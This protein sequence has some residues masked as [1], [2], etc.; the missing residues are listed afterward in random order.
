[1]ADVDR[2]LASVVAEVLH[3]MEKGRLD[4]SQEDVAL[5]RR[6]TTEFS[7]ELV[8]LYEENDEL[9]ARVEQLEKTSEAV[10][11]QV[12]DSVDFLTQTDAQ[13]AE[14]VDLLKRE[15]QASEANSLAA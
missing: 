13:L 8:S 3:E 4:I 7:S 6:L 5:L 15:L 1:M 11:Q 9:F 10:K 14:E 12:Y 2:T